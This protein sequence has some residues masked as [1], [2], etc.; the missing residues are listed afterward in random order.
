MARLRQR[1]SVCSRGFAGSHSLSC[2][3]LGLSLPSLKQWH[4]VGAVKH[5]CGSKMREKSPPAGWRSQG[6]HCW[7]AECKFWKGTASIRCLQTPFS[8][9]PFRR[10]IAHGV[11]DTGTADVERWKNLKVSHGYVFLGSP[12]TTRSP[13]CSGATVCSLP[14]SEQEH[15]CVKYCLRCCRTGPIANKA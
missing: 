8:A 5:R 12:L 1:D 13:E 7:S 3:S 9:F 14:C 2:Q 6:K 11:T 4:S 10:G 15:S